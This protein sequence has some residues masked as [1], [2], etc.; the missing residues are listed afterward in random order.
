[1]LT[2]VFQIIYF[3]QYDFYR[4]TLNRIGKSEMETSLLKLT[5]LK[6]GFPQFNSHYSYEKYEEWGH[7]LDRGPISNIK[8]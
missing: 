5:M 3:I 1:M 4:I 2:R 7:Q 6:I 8:M